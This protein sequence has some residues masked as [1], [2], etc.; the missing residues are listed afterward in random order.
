M[1]GP[2]AGQTK[3]FEGQDGGGHGR[4]DHG[5]AHEG[6]LPA[7]PVAQDEKTRAGGQ[8]PHPVGAV[9][10]PVGQAQFLGFQNVDGIS[11]HRQI[12]GR[13]GQA[14]QA[15]QHPELPGNGLGHQ[16]GHG[17]KRQDNGPLGRHQPGGPGAEAVHQGAPENFEAPGQPQ[18]AQETDVLQGHPL[19]SQV[20][21][22]GGKH[23]TVGHPFGEIQ[24]PHHHQLQGEGHIP[25]RHRG[26]GHRPYTYGIGRLIHFQIVM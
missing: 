9:S 1:D 10:H 23:K 16:A 19:P 6:R 5:D 26:S 13:R 25:G 8:G 20:K 7:Y 18:E 14:Q 3:G 22:Q 17:Q 15:G 24:D 2:R 12:L 4:H 11:I 21:G